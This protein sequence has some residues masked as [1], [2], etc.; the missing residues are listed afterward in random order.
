MGGSCLFMCMFLL[1]LLP[2]PG[3]A[4][5]I[6]MTPCARPARARAA[7]TCCH[8]RQDRRGAHSDVPGTPMTHETFAAAMES[9][10]QPLP[11]FG[12]PSTKHEARA[13]ARASVVR[14]APRA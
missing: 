1:V 7:I 3:W 6:Q 10:R 8:H 11:L 13:S 2:S 4:R 5:S 12:I 9:L 14:A